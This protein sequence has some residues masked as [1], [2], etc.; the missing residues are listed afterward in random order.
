MD[1]WANIVG[2]VEQSRFNPDFYPS[3]LQG[4]ARE[5]HRRVHSCHT[6][7]LWSSA[8]DLRVAFD[9]DVVIPT[10]KGEVKAADLQAKVALRGYKAFGRLRLP[11]G[12]GLFLDVASRW[13]VLSVGRELLLVKLPA[14]IF[15]DIRGCLAVLVEAEVGPELLRALR[16]VPF[17]PP[18]ARGDE[19]V[20]ISAWA[21]AV[22]GGNW[23]DKEGIPLRY[24]LIGGLPEP[25]LPREVDSR[26]RFRREVK[27]QV[28]GRGVHSARS[29]RGFVP[30][31]ETDAPVADVE[32]AAVTAADLQRAVAALTDVERDIVQ[33]LLQGIERNEVTRRIAHRY[34]VSLRRAQQVV[35]QTLQHLRQHLS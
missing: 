20:L 27:S 31:R 22:M 13:V 10:T 24:A 34:G 18:E 35:A 21:T 14:F 7:A 6:Y 15:W 26:E 28:F 25:P 23:R 11:P 30:L 16:R 19:G 12:W 1:V 5:L 29:Q 9:S 32:G 8:D 3:E 17:L 33:L 2:F 4:R